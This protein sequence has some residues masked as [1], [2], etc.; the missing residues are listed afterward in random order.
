MSVKEVVEVMEKK[1]TRNWTVE[2][3]N[4]FVSTVADP[5]TKF[6]LTFEWKALEK[7]ATK[8]VFGAILGKLSTAFMEK[9]FKTLNEKS[10]KG[11]E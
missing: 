3:T 7:A 10:L 4:L 2:Q 1:T 11:K 9:L 8:E 5:A 6:I